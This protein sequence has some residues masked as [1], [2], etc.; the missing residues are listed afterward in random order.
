MLAPHSHHEHGISAGVNEVDE[1]CCGFFAF[2]TRMV[3]AGAG[4]LD[5]G[6]QWCAL[7]AA[8]KEIYGGYENWGPQSKEATA[9]AGE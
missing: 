7:S 9:C 1:A 6:T 4:F 8:I 3:V 2:G 5:C